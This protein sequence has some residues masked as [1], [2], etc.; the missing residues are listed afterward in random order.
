[1]TPAQVLVI[2]GCLAF[3]G[4]TIWYFWLWERRSTGATVAGNSQE[5]TVRVKGGYDPEVI[6]L[7]AGIPARLVF[8]REESSTCSEEVLIP[9][10]KKRAFLP[11]GKPVSIEFTPNDPGEY[12]FTCQM[13]MHR[14]KLIV[15]N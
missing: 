15:E 14:G 3:I 13:G 12:D 1:M 5:I 2:L 10:F 9:A 11:E 4:W 6:L 7:K 8:L